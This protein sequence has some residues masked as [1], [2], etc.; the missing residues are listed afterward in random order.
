MVLLE[1]TVKRPSFGAGCPSE[2]AETFQTFNLEKMHEVSAAMVRVV[3]EV[4]QKRRC[5]VYLTGGYV[6]DFLLGSELTESDL[7]FAVA[8]NPVSFASEVAE[9]LK[10]RAVTL[11]F[12]PTTVRVIRWDVN[13]PDATA[14]FTELKGNLKEDA[15]HR[16]FTCNALFVDVIELARN[17]VAPILDILGGLQHLMARS[18]VLASRHSFKDDPLRILRAFRLSATLNLQIPP[19]TKASIVES[20]PLL[21][22]APPERISMELAWILQSRTAGEQI[23]LM[24]ETGVLTFLLPELV[25]LKEIPAAGYHHLDGFNHTVE[26]LKMAEKAMRGETE[27][28]ELNELLVKVQDAFKV[29]FGY[30]RYGNWVLKF[31]TLLH[32][33]AKPLTMTVDEEGDL[34]FY[35]HEKIGAEIAGQ[36]CERLKLSRRERET[37]TALVRN[38]MR[39]VGLAGAR[40]LTERALNRFWKDLGEIAGIYC[41]VLSAADLMATCGPDMTAEKR[42]RHY[43][44][45]RKL[46]QTYFTIQEAKERVR[47]VTGDEIM[48]RYNLEPSP[49]VGKALRLVEEAVL[50]GKVKTKDEAWALLDA[51]IA[52]WLSDE[53][54]KTEP[55]SR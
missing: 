25:K 45:L 14:D 27:D 44:V 37:V 50:E 9:R 33:I 7:D 18:L 49:L 12:D 24:D 2:M 51:A 15:L 20:A 5:A 55:K 26:A 35:G 28:N 16:D 30:K 6:R 47:L 10:A 8:T 11:H 21:L 13:H 32:D 42:E 36:I 41:V 39:P 53:E 29:R 48:E 31:A 52:E 17:G 23:S 43:F 22:N 54:I 19:E 3:A 1:T 40:Y 38:H 46:M 34:H 4:A